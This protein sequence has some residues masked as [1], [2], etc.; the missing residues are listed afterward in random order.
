MHEEKTRLSLLVLLVKVDEAVSRGIVARDLTSSDQLGENLLGKL[1]AQLNS[2]LV[3]RV[4]IPNHSLN[5]D[6]V[7]IHRNQS[8]Q[9]TRGQL[10][11]HDRVGGLVATEHL[12]GC[13][14]IHLRS[15]QRLVAMQLLQNRLLVLASHQ[16]LS[17]SEKVG[18]QDIVVLG[19]GVVGLDGGQEITGGNAGSLMNQLVEGVL[20]V[21]TGLTDNPGASAV[22]DSLTVSVPVFAVRLHIALLE[23]GREAVHVLIVGEDGVDLGIE[24]VDVP[25]A[26]DGKDNRQ[27]LVE[28]GV[29]K[30]LVHLVGS[31]QEL[32]E[33]VESD[34]K[35]DRETDGGPERVAASDPV[36]ELEHVGG[37]DSELCDRLSVCRQCNEM[38]RNM[39]LLLGRG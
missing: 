37:I 18:Q 12:V 29:D 13:N 22:G 15:R 28:G 24:K 32:V 33:V 5:E 20:T 30:V 8:S 6:L 21:G 19:K 26:E 4:D 3:E 16:R 34:V 25:D 36:P 2:P 7:L 10:L 27:V 11:E 17:L 35:G 38:L 14:L 31:G 1:L 39:C 9:G 23:V